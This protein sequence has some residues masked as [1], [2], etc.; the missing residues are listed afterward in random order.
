MLNRPH[1]SRGMTLIE[2]LIGLAIVG[3]LL[4]I[5]MPAFNTFIANSKVRNAAEA[6]QS[7]LALARSAAM[8]R[9]QNVE[10]LLTNDVVDL[11]TVG[12]IAPATNGIHWVVRV[13][14]PATGNYELVETKSGYEG[15]GQSEGATSVLVAASN[16]TITFR[17]LGGTQGA[18]GTATFDF[19]NPGAGACHTTATPAPI[20]CLRVQVSIAGQVRVCD[21]STS[22]PDTRAC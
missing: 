13:L 8:G 4:G 14:D 5:G 9:N 18:A 7:G 6:L 2:L 19:S 3:L 11:G 1:R 22:V 21:P 20:R 16:A 12:T 17:G 15:S 10:F